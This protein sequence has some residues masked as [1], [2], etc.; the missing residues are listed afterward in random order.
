MSTEVPASPPEI[1]AV[2]K[3]VERAG[4]EERGEERDVEGGLERGIEGVVEL[5]PREMRSRI[6]RS[7]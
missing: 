5:I 1:R 6:A 4:D 2:V 7:S 3:G